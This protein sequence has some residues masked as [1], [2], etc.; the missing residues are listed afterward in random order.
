MNICLKTSNTADKNVSRALAFEPGM[1]HA[2][3]C[4]VAM[5]THHEL[6][7]IIQ[8]SAW[9]LFERSVPLYCTASLC[10]LTTAVA[11]SLK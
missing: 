10:P 7:C 3:F 8:V 9:R 1:W 5:V 6:V 2:A 4:A 11:V